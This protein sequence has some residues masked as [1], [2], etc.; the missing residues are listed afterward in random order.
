MFARSTVLLSTALLVL[1]QALTAAPAPDIAS[2]DWLTGCWA[3]DDGGELSEECW[4]H[5][6][7]GMM[8]GFNRT[9]SESGSA[10]EFLRL[11][12]HPD[13]IAYYASPSG[14]SAVPFVLVEN[15]DGLAV[16]ANPEHDFPQRLTYRR[17]GDR[18]SA[19]V[20]A[21]DGKSGR[22]SSWSG[23]ARRPRGWINRVHQG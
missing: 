13:G 16:F 7:G 17:E 3:G 5:P 22:D 12:P 18:L 19:R 6:A 10:F 14:G 23:G 20:E 9:V 11:G 15:G 21:L 1:T 4:L 2:L 8:L